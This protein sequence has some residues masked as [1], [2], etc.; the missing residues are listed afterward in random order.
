MTGS[1]GQK[2]VPASFFDILMVH[3]PPLPLQ[4]KFAKIVERVEKL[5]EAQ[6]KSREKIDELFNSL[7]QR[8][9]NGELVI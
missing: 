3:L 1:A 9:F 6:E 2:R 7:M 4:Q 5:K 8:A